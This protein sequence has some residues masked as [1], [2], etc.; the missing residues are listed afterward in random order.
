MTNHLL[1]VDIYGIIYELEQQLYNDIENLDYYKENSTKKSKKYIK[2]ME[3][4][5][6]KIQSQ[7][8]FYYS[9]NYKYL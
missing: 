3:K 6:N 1:L 5:I 4:K 8:H 9:F 7:L 2:S